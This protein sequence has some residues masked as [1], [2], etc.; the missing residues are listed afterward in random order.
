MRTFACVA[1]ILW[2][3]STASGQALCITISP[4]PAPPATPITISGYAVSPN[5]LFSQSVC[6]VP[7]IHSGTPNGPV[8]QALPC[9]FVPTAIPG[10]GSTAPPRT[11]TWTP[12]PQ[13]APGL[14]WFEIDWVS[15][16]FGTPTS[17][18]HGVTIQG[19]P[20]GPVLSGAATTPWAAPYLLALSAPAHPGEAY[21]VALSASTN[22]G[23]SIA[24]GL[25]LSL[26]VDAVFSLTFPTPDPALF[27]NFQGVL[28]AAGV[29][30]GIAIL[31][32][33]LFLGCVPLHAEAAVISAAG[34]V[35]LSNEFSFTIQ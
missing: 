8:I 5:G 12:G 17:E 31:V 35:A 11:Y 34:A 3:A 32:P 24:P 10:C 20:P 29:A 28:D 7:I 16:P 25:F 6:F 21:A 19:T 9:A 1:A 14:Y 18:F 4:N 13:I 2:V 15:A 30:N 27:Q 22:T 33:P 26:D 23:L